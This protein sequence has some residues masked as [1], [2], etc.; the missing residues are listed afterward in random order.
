M[1]PNS[2][3]WRARVQTIFQNPDSSLN[4]RHSI[5]TILRRPLT[6]FR[7]DLAKCDR[8]A[9]V[10]RLLDRVRL[11]ADFAGRYPHQ[12]SGGEKQRVAIARALAARPDVIICDE[13]T[14]GLDAAVQAAIA[15]LLR[16]IQSE[17]GTALVFITHDLGMLRHIADRVAVMYLGEVVELCEVSEL[18]AA[19]WHPYTEALLSSSHSVDPDSETRRVRL[20]GNLPKR[21]EN[22]PGCPFASRCPRHLGALCETTYPPRREPKPGHEILCHIDDDALSTVPPIWHFSDQLET[23]P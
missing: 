5:S 3:A 18:D 20:T 16:E 17:S 19:P 12:L 11:P 13:I 6:L 9:E 14:S 1:A 10:R 15:Q 2:A 21:T 22:L 7:A 23:S 4:P 8:D